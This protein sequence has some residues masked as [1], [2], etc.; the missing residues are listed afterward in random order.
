MTLKSH[1]WAYIQ[2]KIGSEIIHAPQCMYKHCS[3]IYNSQDIE[4]T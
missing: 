2:R 1:S 3:S 4:V